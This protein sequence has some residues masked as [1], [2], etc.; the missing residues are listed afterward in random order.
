MAAAESS[1][2][3]LG[4]WQRWGDEHEEINRGQ[5]F[6]FP[7]RDLHELGAHTHRLSTEYMFSEHAAIAPAVWTNAV[8]G[9]LGKKW[10]SEPTV[11]S[12][13]SHRGKMKTRQ[14]LDF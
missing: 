8:L 12:A 4:P 7:R 11:V 3:T 14:M 13:K 9:A 5:L 1:S 10:T 6:L 2:T